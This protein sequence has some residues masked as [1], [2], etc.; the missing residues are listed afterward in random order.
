MTK[1]TS[2]RK[3]VSVKLMPGEAVYVASIE[4]LD[5]IANTYTILGDEEQNPEYKEQW[6]GIAQ[7][8][9][10]WVNGTINNTEESEVEE[11]W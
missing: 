1:K 11:D 4:I 5:H 8:I 9:T 3:K 6:Y 2:H 7:S 10:E